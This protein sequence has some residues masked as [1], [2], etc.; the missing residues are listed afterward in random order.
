MLAAATM[1]VLFQFFSCHVHI[2]SRKGDDKVKKKKICFMV[3]KKRPTTTPS[4]GLGVRDKKK[5][6]GHEGI[7]KKMTG[8]FPGQNECGG[9]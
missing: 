5:Y 1:E 9:K 2:V 4:V 7:S 8:G 3:T 6:K